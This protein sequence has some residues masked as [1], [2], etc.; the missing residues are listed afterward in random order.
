MAKE[1]AISSLTGHIVLPPQLNDPGSLALLRKSTDSAPIKREH[2]TKA[3][4]PV[5]RR[6]PRHRGRTGVFLSYNTCAGVASI[7]YPQ[8]AP[9][10]PPMGRIRNRVELSDGS[11][12]EAIRPEDLAKLE[13][14]ERALTDILSQ[15]TQWEV[16]MMQR[17]YRSKVLSA[18]HLAPPRE[19]LKRSRSAEAA[20]LTTLAQ[21]TQMVARE[22]YNGIPEDEISTYTERIK[23]YESD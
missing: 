16:A 6:A 19:E 17:N 20:R 2:A 21:A 10:A 5:K 7:P 8:V 3:E 15:R 4:I 18:R 1:E 22:A 23:F 14:Q 12:P 9:L 11:K 13:L